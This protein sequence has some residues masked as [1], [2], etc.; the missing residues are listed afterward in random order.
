MVVERPPGI[1]DP[2]L[3]AVGVDGALPGARLSWI[4]VDDILDPENTATPAGRAKVRSWFNKV[5][6]SRRDVEG[7]KIAV[8]NTPYHPDDLTYALEKSGWPTLVMN[9]DGGIYF[10][11]AD[12]F[13]SDD[14]RLS[15]KA[16]D[17]YE[18]ECRLTAH[19]TAAYVVG[20]Y[21]DSPAPNPARDIED[22]VPLWPEKFGRKQIA[23]L[24]TE[25]RSA[26][27]DFNQ[28]YMCVCR[29]DESG[30]VK[31]TWIEVCKEQARDCEVY[32]FVEEWKENW[33]TFTGVDLGVGLRS[34]NDKTSI[35][36]VGVRPDQRR[37]ILDID[38][39]RF[40]GETIVSKVIAA[41]DRYNSIIRVENNSA[42]DYI[43]QWVLSK[44]LSIPIRAHTTG[45]NKADPR[46]GLESI[47]VEIENGVWIFPCDQSGRVPEQV[48]ELIEQILYYDPNGHTGD[49]LISMWLAREQARSSGALV[50]D[51]DNSAS[52]SGQTGFSGLMVR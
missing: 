13:D 6:L 4:L 44:D 52:N 34:K 35:F 16:N 1:R 28:L 41:H 46:F 30:R 38:A 45:K 15:D 14:I 10:A 42:Q 40:S 22:F 2:S 23:K 9:C 43:R 31:V 27:T 7:A 51:A 50:R 26:L 24:R 21:E 32:R 48:R 5:V 20:S 17:N 25:Y 29:D 3:V 11:N 39:G 18:A 12:D 33:P 49:I 37:Q 8:T 47:F 19:D 36:T